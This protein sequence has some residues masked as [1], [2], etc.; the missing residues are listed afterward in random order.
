MQLTPIRLQVVQIEDDLKA[1]RALLNQKKELGERDDILPF[2]KAHP[3]LSAFL[4]N[5]SNAAVPDCYAHEYQIGGN[6]AC[7]LLAGS[8]ASNDYVFVEFEDA[9]AES[10]FRIDKKRK[11]PEWSARFEH[12]FSQIVD[13]FYY[14]D[15]IRQTQQFRRDFPAGAP[16]FI[17]MLVIGRS[18][19]L[20]PADKD[21]LIWRKDKVQ[22]NTH[23]VLIYT[24]DEL[25]E[26][27]QD[28]IDALKRLVFQ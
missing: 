17:G 8:S 23:H 27:L 24:F 25:L 9:K 14:L 3:H 10:I 5:F 12:G 15:D 21:R 4:A 1:F 13:W 7:D 20:T 26:R 2:F 6:F 19:F 18:S 22:I 28:R 16:S 11:V